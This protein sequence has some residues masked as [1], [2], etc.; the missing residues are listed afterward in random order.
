VLRCQALGVP[1]SLRRWGN[2]LV[3]DKGSGDRATV[4]TLRDFSLPV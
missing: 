4:S 2:L 3:G 1:D